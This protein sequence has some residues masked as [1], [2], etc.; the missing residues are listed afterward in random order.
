MVNINTWGPSPKP[1]LFPTRLLLAFF[2]CALHLTALARFVDTTQPELNPR[3]LNDAIP[4][5]LIPTS[6]I[7]DQP[8]KSSVDNY[9]RRTLIEKRAEGDELTWEDALNTGNKIL[10]ANRKLL[11]TGKGNSIVRGPAEV[12]RILNEEFKESNRD[13]KWVPDELLEPLLAN[14]KITIEEGEGVFLEIEDNRCLSK[15][16]I[17]YGYDK[18]EQVGF[19]Y[20]EDVFRQPEAPLRLSEVAFAQYTTDLPNSVLKDLKYIY[21][22]SITNSETREFINTAIESDVGRMVVVDEQ[23][24]HV[25]TPGKDEFTALLGSENGRGA[26]YIVND[27]F[28]ELGRKRVSEIHVHAPKPYLMKLVIGDAP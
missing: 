1:Y 22:A 19:I 27:Y 12:R 26:G 3:I 25:F 24:W 28:T 10:A 2:V 20:I 13:K 14:D 5:E 4:H 9:F 21:H 18:N 8:P 17:A 23:E 7:H 16:E 15:F 11:E 6:E